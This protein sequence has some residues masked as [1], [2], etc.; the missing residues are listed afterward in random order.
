MENIWSAF[1]CLS[2]RRSPSASGVS[3]ITYEQILAFKKLTDTP[4][5]PREIKVLEAL[6]DKYVRAMNE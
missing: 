3:P 5:S 4:I 6:D 2:N 1:K